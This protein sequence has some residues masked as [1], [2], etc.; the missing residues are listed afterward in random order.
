MNIWLGMY[1]YLF[2]KKPTILIYVV[3]KHQL[4]D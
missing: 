1:I 3:H 4:I 2:I